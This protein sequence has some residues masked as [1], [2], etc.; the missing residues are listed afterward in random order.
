MGVSAPSLHI[1]STDSM[2]HTPV[3]LCMEKS[4]GI[5]DITVSTVTVNLHIHALYKLNVW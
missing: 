2:I 3:R 5:F 1:E 4:G